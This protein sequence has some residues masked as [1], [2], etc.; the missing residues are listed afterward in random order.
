V[1]KASS[2]LTIRVPKDLDRQLTLEARG[3]RTTRSEVAREILETSLRGST[4]DPRA[5]ARRQSVLASRLCARTHG[6]VIA[7]AD[8]ADLRRLDPDVPVG[9]V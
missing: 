4:D 7:T 3:H 6:Q 1:T 5:E 9:V 8:P 2:V